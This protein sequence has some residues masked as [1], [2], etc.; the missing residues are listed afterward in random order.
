MRQAG[1]E[2][3]VTRR[4]DRVLR[5]ARWQ[6]VGLSGEEERKPARVTE[7]HGVPTLQAPHGWSANVTPML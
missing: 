4:P 2:E 6:S 7:T 5:G 3:T 1:R